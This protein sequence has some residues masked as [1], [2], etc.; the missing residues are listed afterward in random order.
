MVSYMPTR[1]E[2]TQLTLTGEWSDGKITN[3][4]LISC[5]TRRRY[6]INIDHTNILLCSSTGSGALYGCVQQALRDTAGALERYR[7]LGERMISEQAHV[8]SESQVISLA[9]EIL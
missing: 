2:I 4:R 5:I 7:G 9:V 6:Q 8:F 3:V 1:R